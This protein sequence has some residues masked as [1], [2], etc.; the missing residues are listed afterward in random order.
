MQHMLQVHHTLTKSLIAGVCHRDIKPENILMMSAGTQVSVF[1][2]LYLLT[3]TK[4]QLLTQNKLADESSPLYNH[5]K[6]AD[7]G[8][9]T[10]K[11]RGYCSTMAT[12]CGTPEF[13][14][15]EL[16]N[17]VGHRGTQAAGNEV[18]YMYA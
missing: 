8:L 1:V 18:H 7:F 10:D 2:P 9:S 14:S 12:P 6:I 5:I 13:S 15:P 4:V 11:A 16:L 17:C 3:S